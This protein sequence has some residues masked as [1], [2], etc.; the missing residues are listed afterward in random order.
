M[1]VVKAEE[2][3][4]KIF[5]KSEHSLGDLWDITRWAKRHTTGVP[6]EEKKAEKL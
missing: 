5:S 1:D 6:E 4:E 2:Q 3:K